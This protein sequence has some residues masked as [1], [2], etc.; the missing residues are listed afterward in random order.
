VDLKTLPPIYHVPIVMDSD[1]LKLLKPSRPV[2]ACIRI[3]LPL[4]FSDLCP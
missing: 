2:Q 3:A 4:Y 1:S